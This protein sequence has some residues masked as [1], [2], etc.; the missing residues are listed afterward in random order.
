MK[1]RMMPGIVLTALALQFLGSDAWS[2]MPTPECNSKLDR[3]TLEKLKHASHGEWTLSEDL[4]PETANTTTPLAHYRTAQECERQADELRADWC[5]G[6]ECTDR[7]H[8]QL[9]QPF[10]PDDPDGPKAVI[11]A[12]KLREKLR[13]KVP[14]LESVCAGVGSSV[15]QTEI[16][17]FVLKRT[18]AVQTAVPTTFGGYPIYISTVGESRFD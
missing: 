12:N 1:L 15:G 10:H 11:A 9:F 16:E 4:E 3:A 7:H 2:Q 13:G 8:C 18:P 17:V 14:G 5:A 6:F